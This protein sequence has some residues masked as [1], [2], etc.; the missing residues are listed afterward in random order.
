[1]PRRFVRA[2]V[3]ARVR[4]IVS[5]YFGGNLEEIWFAEQERVPALLQCC[6]SVMFDHAR[7]NTGVL[8][9]CVCVPTLRVRGCAWHATDLAMRPRQT[10]SERPLPGTYL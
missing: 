5:Q 3:R 9:L 4:R 8:A 2:C 10:C 6:T 7:Q 1:M